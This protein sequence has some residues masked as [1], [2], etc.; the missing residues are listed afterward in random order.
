MAHRNGLHKRPLLRLMVTVATAFWCA[1]G[2][3]GEEPLHVRIDVL[4]TG[5]NANLAAPACDDGA[6][7][8]R[9]YLDLAGTIPSATEARSFLDDKSGNKRTDCI[10]RLL[11][12]PC[13]AR[14]MT[15]VFDTMLM[16]RRP[17][18]HVEI[19]KWQAYLYEGF[20]ADK[21]LDQLFRELLSADGA[22][23]A[24][25]GAA[26]FVLDRDA[27]P[28]VLTRDV[29]R[30]VFGHDLQCAQ[31]HDH[32]LIDD[33]YQRD[34]YEL[35]A[36]FNRTKLFNEQGKTMMLMDDPHGE[37]SYQSVFDP[38]AKGTVHP[39]VPGGQQIEEPKLEGDAA[40]AVAPAKDVRP[41]P[42]F[43][44][45]AQLPAEAT[46]CRQFAR[47]LANRLWAMLMGKGIVEPVDLQHSDNPPLHP[48]LLEL[49][50][51]ELIARKFNAKSLLREI[52]LSTTYQRSSELP[53]NLSAL[54][55]DAAAQIPALSQER[56]RLVNTAATSADA[57]KKVSDAL[58]AAQAPM[59]PLMDELAKR[60]AAMAETKKAA[61]EA[62][63]PVA[64]A[65]AKLSDAQLAAQ[66]L[67]EALAKAKQAAEKMPS[68]KDLVAAADAVKACSEKL[69]AEIS[70]SS[71]QLAKLQ[72]AAAVAAEQATSANRAAD[73]A[74]KQ[75]EAVRAQISALEP[76]H[77][78]ATTQAAY[79]SALVKAT[80]ARI[81]AAQALAELAAAS[82]PAKSAQLRTQLTSLWSHQSL[83]GSIRPLSPEQFAWSLMK[84]IG[85]VDAELASA[86]A[87]VYRASSPSEVDFPDAVV[88]TRQIER[89]V[90]AKLKPHI[91]RFVQLFG[92]EAG[93]PQH[94]F[95]ATADQA[96]Y[97]SNGNEVKS[98]LAPNGVDLAARLLKLDDPK[99]LA[100]ELY[101][102]V[103]TRRPIDSEVA[104]V[105]DYLKSRG[106]DKPEKKAEKTA[107]IQEM[108]W[109]LLASVEFRFVR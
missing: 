56:D 95:F 45:R 72:A 38:S 7:L 76:Q 60:N 79:D 98:W 30:I 1:A 94:E 55:A 61:D 90:V 12:G 4:V 59:G 78:A 42:K 58:T 77:D 24:L 48:Q 46:K 23:P 35:L 47:N 57:L 86:A 83:M 100:D 13:F 102:S 37:V 53:E 27:D 81:A 8:R 32:P 33:Y 66:L 10:D 107:A 52:A 49:L 43:S 22:D 39:R 99:Q 18:K 29:G 87:E 44:R 109:S 96:L 70:A 19:T 14:Q 74:N 15:Q 41:V 25:R 36:F 75:L 40:Y 9:V 80:E 108:V 92:A 68:N 28:N 65:Q 21:P 71:D 20:A 64:A 91:D 63:K 101:L 3:H 16:E 73:E 88:R 103:F 6:F 82:D 106:V 97:L 69:V 54:T 85:V 84:A 89:A 11:A 93:Q 34:Y 5:G 31:C 2:A 62:V 50:T 67:G 104:S 17:Q 51:D 26:R 105:A